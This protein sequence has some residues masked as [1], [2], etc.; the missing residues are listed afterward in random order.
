MNVAD[1]VLVR[2]LERMNVGYE[3]D[4]EEQEKD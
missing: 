1:Q 4:V 2:V 3:D